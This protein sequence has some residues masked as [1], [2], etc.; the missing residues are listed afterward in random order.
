V[1][2]AFDLPKEQRAAIQD[3]VN[4]AFSADVRIRFE[5]TPDLV[6]GIDLATDGHKVGW[7]IADYLGSL[8][9]GVE[10]L[11]KD[12]EETDAKAAPNPEPKPKAEAK[13]ETR[14]QAKPDPK[15]ELKVESMPETKSP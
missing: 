10:E 4:R 2:S 14:A 3:A 9:K 12:K 1:R 11:L 6:S 7:S 13:A 5:T 15:P 8:E